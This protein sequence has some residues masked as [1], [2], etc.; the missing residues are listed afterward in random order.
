MPEVF[1]LRENYDESALILT[2]LR[3]RIL[4]SLHNAALRQ[5]RGK[6][7]R[8]RNFFDFSMIKRISPAAALVFAS[9]FDRGRAFFPVD[10]PVIERSRWQ[11]Q[12]RALLGGIGF[13]DL[14]DI[15]LSKKEEDSISVRIARFQTSDRVGNPHA[16][17]LIETLADMIVKADAEAFDDPELAI[18]RTRLFDALVEATENALH[19]AYPPDAPLPFRVDRWWMTGAVYPEEKRMLIAVYDQGIS[20]PGSLPQWAGYAWIRAGL[21]RLLRGSEPSPEDDTFDAE[22]LRAHSEKI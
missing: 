7:G 12:V 18:S 11:R 20:I 17:K 1:C 2:E 15:P 14:L 16:G 4:E 5:A 13:F 21:Q 9:E 10:I 22:R 8:I 3:N 19:H 6:T